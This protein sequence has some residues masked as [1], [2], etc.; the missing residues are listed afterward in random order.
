MQAFTILLVDFMISPFLCQNKF[1]L[2]RKL[3]VCNKKS[4]ALLFLVAVYFTGVGIHTAIVLQNLYW[5]FETATPRCVFIL[6]LIT[7]IDFEIF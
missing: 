7:N 4:W 3:V 5:I 1:Y 2:T 6:D